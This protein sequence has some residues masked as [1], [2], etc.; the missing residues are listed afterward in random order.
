M[1]TRRDTLAGMAGTALL[2]A[3]PKGPYVYPATAA[4]RREDADVLIRAYTELHPGLMR[5]LTPAAWAANAARFRREA[6]AAEIPAALWLAT[7]RFTAAV[8]CG[9]SF[10]N[11]FNQG[12]ALTSQLVERPD[13]L[14]FLFRWLDKRMVVTRAL[15]DVPGLRAGTEVTAL[16]GE[17][18]SRLLTRLMPLA[19]A[20]GHNDA[21]RVADLEVRAAGRYEDFDVLRSVIGRPGATMVRLDLRAADGRQS[22]IEAPLLNW[23]SRPH[24]DNKGDAALWTAAMQGPAMVVTMGDWATYDSKWDWRGF[25]ETTVDDAIAANA[26]AIIV[27]LRGN[28]G[29]EDCGDVLLS[30]LTDRPLDHAPAARRVRYRK[31]PADLDPHLDTWDDSFRTLGVDAVDDRHDGLLTLPP[32][33]ALRIQP[34]GPRYTGKLIVLVDAECS[35]ATFG[36]AQTVRSSGRGTIVGSPTGGNRRGTNGGSFFFVRM[37]NSRLEADLPLIGSF[38]LTP[39]PDAGLIPDVI[40]RPTQAS[41]AAGVDPGMT[42][43][44]RLV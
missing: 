17:P 27:D 31:T 26:R 36:F 2:A 13:R 42:A 35:S 41:I 9:H 7:T 10:V 21:K 5:Y 20:D 32:E 34:S 40:A 44:L 1:L 12:K 22:R 43:A 29:G 28:E 38:P 18:A 37:P 4:L 24:P 15:A 19:R 25:I 14:P 16:D 8:R 3:A 23:D 6:E 39:Q 33:A 11:P 30:R